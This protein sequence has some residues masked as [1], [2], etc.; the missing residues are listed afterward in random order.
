[1]AG[2][3]GVFVESIT[4]ASRSLSF[5]SGQLPKL[6]QGADTRGAAGMF[7]KIKRRKFKVMCAGNACSGFITTLPSH[8][9]IIRN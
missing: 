2:D 7:L 1:M 6:E 5:D 4:E 8:L 3:Y 9:Q